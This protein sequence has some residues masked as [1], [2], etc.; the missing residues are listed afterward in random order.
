[1][2]FRDLPTLTRRSFDL[3]ITQAQELNDGAILRVA[4]QPRPEGEATVVPFEDAA[5]GSRYEVL[6]WPDGTVN[7]RR[8]VA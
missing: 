5:T 4:G 2:E 7:G 1:M 3:Y 8:Q 6:V